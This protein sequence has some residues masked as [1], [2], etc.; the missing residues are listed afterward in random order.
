M[1]KFPNG[2]WR[3]GGPPLGNFSHIIPF[4]FWRRP[5]ACVINSI[6]LSGRR[7]QR[8]KSTGPQTSSILYFVG[9][10]GTATHCPPQSVS[11]FCQDKG[12]PA[13]QWPIDGQIMKGVSR[14]KDK[15]IK[16]RPAP[17]N[18]R[19]VKV[20]AAANGPLIINVSARQKGNLTWE[21]II[22]NHPSIDI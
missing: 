11:L 12:V 17:I 19:K 3:G 2:G 15:R 14:T 21:T 5:L 9:M 1:W 10:K 18:E 8:T 4:F 16:G 22:S 7:G 13:C 20:S 6:S